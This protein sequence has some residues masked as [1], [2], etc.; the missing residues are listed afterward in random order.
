MQ[1]LMGMDPDKMIIVLPAGLIAIYLIVSIQKYLCERKNQN[2]G[3][4][5]PAICFI[6]ATI[7]AVRPL[8]VSDINQYDGLVSFCIR[9]W[10]TFNIPTIVFL[11]PYYKRRKTASQQAEQSVQPTQID[12]ANANKVDE[13]TMADKADK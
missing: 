1:A 13:A 6:A 9:M 2:V 4:I 10:L 8:L 5:I 3:L 12:E 7:L 11:F